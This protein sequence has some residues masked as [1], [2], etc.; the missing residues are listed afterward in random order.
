[1]A[2]RREMHYSSGVRIRLL[3]IETLILQ[4]LVL[5]GK[6]NHLRNEFINENCDCRNDGLA[7]CALLHSYLPEMIPYDELTPQDKKQNFSLAF[8]AAERVGVSTTLVSLRS[9]CQSK[10]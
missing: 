6:T 2:G 9:T 10:P 3:G 4:T 8:A 1:M 7:L 5:H